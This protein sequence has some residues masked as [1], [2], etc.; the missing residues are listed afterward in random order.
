MNVDAVVAGLAVVATVEVVLGV[1]VVLDCKPRDLLLVEN[2]CQLAATGSNWQQLAAN[3]WAYLT[4]VVGR[5]VVGRRVAGLSVVDEI[6]G[7]PE[8]LLLSDFLRQKQLLQLLGLMV[9]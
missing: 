5:R 6:L 1:V 3:L 9:K 8:D 2:C 4:V 7:K